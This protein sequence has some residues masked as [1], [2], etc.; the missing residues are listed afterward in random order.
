MALAYMYRRRTIAGSIGA[1]ADE[2]R[3]ATT[4]PPP[5]PV[6]LKTE[7]SMGD[8][9]LSPVMAVQPPG[10]GAAPWCNHHALPARLRVRRRPRG[11]RHSSRQKMFLGPQKRSIYG[12]ATQIISGQHS[13]GAEP[14]GGA[15]TSTRPTSYD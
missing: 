2:G 5:R 11:T 13:W 15:D 7:N 14:R 6:F 10:G 3:A 9:W 12:F 1:T 4:P 8:S